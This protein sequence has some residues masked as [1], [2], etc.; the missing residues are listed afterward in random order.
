M[1]VPKIKPPQELCKRCREWLTQKDV[2]WNDIPHCV[3]EGK[4]DCS[5]FIIG[6]ADKCPYFNE[7]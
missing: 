5:E 2:G 6:F 1:K 7:W 4:P 3:H